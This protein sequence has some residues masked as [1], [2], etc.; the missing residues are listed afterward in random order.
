MEIRRLSLTFLLV[1]SLA[2]P[3]HSFVHTLI[4]SVYRFDFDYINRNRIIRFV[5]LTY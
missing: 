4:H 5:F 3:I 2:L 1:F